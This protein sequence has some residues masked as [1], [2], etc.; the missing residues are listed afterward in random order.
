MAEEGD[1]TAGLERA[2]GKGHFGG[3][4]M[5]EDDTAAQRAETAAAEGAVFKVTHHGPLGLGDKYAE[6]DR[7]LLP[8]SGGGRLAV[9]YRVPAGH[10]ITVQA[11]LVD[12]TVLDYGVL[13]GYA[14]ET[15][16]TV[17]Q[18]EAVAF[19]RKDEVLLQIAGNNGYVLGFLGYCHTQNTIIIEITILNGHIL[20]KGAGIL[21]F[22]IHGRLW[23]GSFDTMNHRIGNDTSH[24]RRKSNAIAEAVVDVT[25]INRDVIA[26]PLYT[27]LRIHISIRKDPY[28]V[29]AHMSDL[30]VAHGH[31]S[32]IRY[33]NAVALLAV[34]RAVVP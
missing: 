16:R 8:A 31:V 17:G 2:V 1:E 4:G 3:R 9:K 30:H 33:A 34:S 23:S 24:N 14:D 22:D 7:V 19:I 28:T 6:G 18:K 25:V 20:V 11:E 29:A 5:E 26:L 27:I 15:R 21:R 10:V 13:A 32:A 12:I